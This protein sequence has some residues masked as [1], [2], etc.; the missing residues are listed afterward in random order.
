LIRWRGVIARALRGTPLRLAI[1]AILAVVATW[2][3]LRSPS[4]NVFRDAQVLIGY[5]DAARKSVVEYREA[6]LWDPYYC[7]GMYT[8]GSPQ[9]RFAS[10]TF[11]FTLFF[12]TFRGE[13]LTVFLMIVIGLEGAFRYARSRGATTLGSALAAPAFALSGSFAA[14]PAM[15]WLNFM[16]FELI[17]W[18]LYGLRRAFAG[19][20]WGIAVAAAALAWIV[21]MGG[22]YAAPIA[23]LLCAY[24]VFAEAFRLRKDRPA[25][26]R[27]AAMAGLVAFAGLFLAAVR[28]WPV[29]ETLRMAPRIIGGSPGNHGLRLLRQMT[30]PLVSGA[31]G[32][33]FGPDGAFYVG[34]VLAIP[35]GIGVLT[36]RGRPMLIAGFLALWL[37]AGY[38]SVPSL[39]DWLR[40]LPLYS[41][42]RYPERFLIPFALY[43][44]VLA[45]IG[46][47]V[48]EARRTK[49]M[50]IAH[51]VFAL[52]VIGNVGM[53]VRNHWFAANARQLA[54]PPARIDQEFHQARGTRW[55]AAV[56]AP[57]NRGSLSCWDAFPVP[58]SPALQAD[59]KDEVY[60]EDA[61]SGSAHTTHFSPNRID[62]E[63][64]LGKSAVVRINQNWHPGW[65]ASEGH[66]VLSDGL[67]AVDLPPGKHSVSVVFKPRSGWGGG[68]VSL[69]AL[70]CCGVLVWR[71]KKKDRPKDARELAVDAGIAFAPIVPLLLVFAMWKQPP[72]PDRSMVAPTGDPVVADAPPEGATE[73]NARFEGDIELVAVRATPPDPV[74]GGKTIIEIDWRVGAN[75]PSG[76]G[77]F[78][79]IEPEG[80]DR[81]MADHAT[82]SGVLELE[83][84][85]KGKILRD[86]IELSVA[87]TYSGKSIKV[88]AGLWL[89]RGR[90]T[91]LRVTSHGTLEER[92]NRLL[93]T[94]LKVR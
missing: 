87:D 54:P 49:G 93:I 43:A 10:P 64:D 42:L 14:A 84:A 74:A 34:A 90:G 53:L 75:V 50:A 82:I 61:N 7:G 44:S 6:P 12:G 80:S 24:E 77:V 27:L 18:A 36:R 73:A 67:L 9:S 1:W 13:G 22:T 52:L 48:L 20:R 26:R 66:A 55:A 58:Q 57:M 28:L 51:A 69:A 45:A 32:G 70:A 38:A 17:P 89:Q 83:H 91:R 29:L 21:G 62:F 65:V 60:V 92:E 41:T 47:S 19:H 25:L 33:N 15:G 35:V 4:M 63:A 2:P 59:L 3:M 86:I 72:I 23:G 85:P 79:H 68:I 8:L 40:S 78:A 5:E 37:A 16:G 30:M 39:F 46:F 76:V 31:G 56:Y 94:T 11:L 88:W 71:G 81:M